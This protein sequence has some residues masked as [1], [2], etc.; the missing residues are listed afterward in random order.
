[1]AGPFKCFLNKANSL[2]IFTSLFGNV[3]ISSEFVFI[4]IKA[5]NVIHAVS[6]NLQAFLFELLYT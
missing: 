5:A 1:M 3:I 4:F 2:P 6:K